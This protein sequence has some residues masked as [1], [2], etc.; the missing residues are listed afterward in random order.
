MRGLH[1]NMLSMC[2]ERGVDLDFACTEYML[3]PGAR[4]YVRTQTGMCADL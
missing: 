3:G 4:A 2:V 1:R